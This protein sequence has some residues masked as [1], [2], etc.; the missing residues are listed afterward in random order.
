MEKYFIEESEKNEIL[1]MH[2]ALMKEQSSKE[3]VDEQD[4]KGGINSE[5]D[6]LRKAIKTGCLKSGKLLTN[7]NRSKFV[8]RATT[9]SGKEVDFSADMSYKFKDGSGSGKWA[10]PQL[11]TAAA[12]EVAAQQTAAQT[13]ADN[14]SKIQT[15]LKKN[16]KRLE[17]LRAEGVDLTTLDKV[18]DT[19]VIGNV[20]LYRPKGSSTTFTA[21][22]STKDFNQDQQS[23]VD[24]FTAKGYKLNPTR[25][26]QS[27]LVKI[28]DKEL[29]APADL[30]PNGLVMWYDPNKQSDI[31]GRDGSVLGSI[32]DNQSVDRNVCRKNIDDYFKSFQRKNS[33][34]ID[35]ATINK[36]KRIVQACKDEHYGKWG[37]AGGGN[38]IDNYLDILSGNKE[39]GPTS[40]GD[41][42]IWRIK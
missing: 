35:P 28:T 26:E 32:L 18:Y 30:F 3:E 38:R 11:A 12:A 36:A 37:V 40:Y 21:G 17:T 10:C 24:N 9:K 5:E 7:A 27:T 31:R 13:S 23:F 15:E 8:Y 29:G 39:G 20:T 1:S 33:I 2:K 41:D 34:V 6:M 14:E 16:W 22:T 4:P 42:S 19:Q 25:L